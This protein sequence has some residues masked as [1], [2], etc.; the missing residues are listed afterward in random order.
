[1]AAFVSAI[2]DKNLSYSDRSALYMFMFFVGSYLQLHWSRASP[3]VPIKT[4][5]SHHGG[6][7]LVRAQDTMVCQLGLRRPLGP[8][9][10]QARGQKVHARTPQYV[11]VRFAPSHLRRLDMC[12]QY[13]HHNDNHAA[14]TLSPH[15]EHLLPQYLLLTLPVH[16]WI[17]YASP[18]RLARSSIGCSSNPVCLPGRRC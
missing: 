12:R 16:M 2:K 7:A 6:S 13:D 1:M 10:G 9:A 5:P 3:G 8:T 17:S 4:R 15:P 14:E 11:K 18:A